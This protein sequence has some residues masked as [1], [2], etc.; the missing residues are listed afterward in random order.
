MKLPPA[1]PVLARELRVR[2]RGRQGWVLLTVY[3]L[4]LAAIVFVVYQAEVGGGVSGDPFSAPSPTR[5]ASVGRSVFEWLVLFMLLLVLF[6]VPGFTAGAIAGERE[7]QTLVPLQVTLL[8]PW[9]IVLGKLL[10][11]FAYLAL[12]V[13][14]TAPFLAVAYLIGGVTMASVLKSVLVVLFVGLCV[15]ALTVCC[16]VLFKRVQIATVVSYAAVLVLLV[17]TLLVWLAAGVVDRARGDDAANPP[18]ELLAMNPL[19]FAADVLADDDAN[20]GG[21]ASPFSPMV[22]I[23]MEDRYGDGFSSFDGGGGFFGGPVPGGRA[24]AVGGGGFVEVADFG[25]A[26]QPPIIGF[27]RNGNPIFATEDDRFPFW[28]M[29]AI[30]FYVVAVAGAVLAIRRLRTPAVTER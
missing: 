28:A 23:L 24:I 14:A 9:Q 16:S 7:R 2:L 1:N 20:I 5:F 30:A 27:D 25:S 13:I 22:D 4:L 11:S 6:L 17:G 26:Q 15:S 3:L 10:A 21:G 12:L 18:A 29:S 19:F 8:R